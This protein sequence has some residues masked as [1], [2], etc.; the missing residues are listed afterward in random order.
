[1]PMIA[2]AISRNFPEFSDKL[3]VFNPLKSVAVG[4]AVYA[5]KRHQICRRTSRSIALFCRDDDG[6]RYVEIIPIGAEL[7]FQSDPVRLTV[8]QEGHDTFFSVCEGHDG[9]YQE[10]IRVMMETSQYPTGAEIE[11]FFT[12]NGQGVL[13]F[14]ANREDKKI[15]A[16]HK[17][18]LV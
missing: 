8:T 17:L 6:D 4:A 9:H 18:K 7:P 3:R 13:L 10:V 12:I 15:T 11:A 2:D 16:E 14:Q 1:M 5:R